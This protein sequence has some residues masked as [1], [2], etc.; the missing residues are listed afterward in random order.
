MGENAKSKH[1]LKN[2]KWVAHYLGASRNTVHQWV[3]ENHI[4]YINLGVS[5]G[6]RVIRFDPDT[7][8]AWLTS[9]TH[10]AEPEKAGTKPLAKEEI[11]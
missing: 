5:G 6:R 11:E 2:V 10:Q 9:R 7:I 4:P 3:L 1:A 8:A